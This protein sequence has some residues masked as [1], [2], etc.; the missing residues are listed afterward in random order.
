MG[1]WFKGLDGTLK[2]KN[3]KNNIEKY[4]FFIKNKKMEHITFPKK[5]A[6]T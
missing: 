5:L 3:Q 4:D 2:L 1:K 6:I